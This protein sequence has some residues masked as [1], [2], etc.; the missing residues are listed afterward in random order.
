MNYPKWN[1]DKKQNK[2]KNLNGIGEWNNFQWPNIGIIGVSE[3]EDVE[4]MDRKITEEIMVKVFQIWWKLKFKA[5]E[6]WRNN[7]KSQ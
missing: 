1:R 6:T 4:G 2:T 7:T 3:C 5:Q